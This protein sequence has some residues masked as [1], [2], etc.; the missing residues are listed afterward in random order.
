[1]HTGLGALSY[2][3]E[4]VE[5]ADASFVQKEYT[6]CGGAMRTDA[7]LT[8]C[9]DDVQ[10]DSSDDTIE[11]SPQMTV[12][13]TVAGLT[14]PPAM[15][16]TSYFDLSRAPSGPSMAVTSRWIDE[17]R[18]R[19]PPIRSAFLA[20]GL[21]TV[22]YDRSV[23]PNSLRCDEEVTRISA[24]VASPPRPR[25]SSAPDSPSRCGVNVSMG[26]T[27]HRSPPP[28]F[29]AWPHAS[30]H[31]S[32][33]A[34]SRAPSQMSGLDVAGLL[35]RLVDRQH[36]DLQQARTEAYQR[37]REVKTEAAHREQ[38]LKVEA[39]Q[40]E[41]RAYQR[42]Q[43]A[44][45]EASQREQRAYQHEKE[46][47]AEAKAEAKAE[48]LRREKQV[49]SEVEKEMEIDRLRRKLAK[50]EAK[51]RQPQLSSAKTWLEHLLLRG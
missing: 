49:R 2:A 43:A 30:S 40:R 42:E 45:A 48:V 36:D 6:S 37:E 10:S 1:M 14:G 34:Q 33:R 44:T 16:T 25:T 50:K 22:A 46:A 28:T 9:G 3:A 39:E 8:I 41:Q 12:R 23:S 18:E 17:Q 38:Q 4:F 51:E 5:R 21:P 32:S 11:L 20:T 29:S 15:A 35:N 47:R 24:S 7:E 31:V 26:G 27:Q 13:G 19:S